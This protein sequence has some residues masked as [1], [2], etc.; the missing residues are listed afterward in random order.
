MR[1]LPSFGWRD[2]LE[3]RLQSQWTAGQTDC[4]LTLVYVLIRFV[5]LGSVCFESFSGTCD[6]LKLRIASVD[7][8]NIEF[9]K[10]PIGGPEEWR[11]QEARERETKGLGRKNGGNQG[12]E[13]VKRPLHRTAA[14]I[15]KRI[16]SN[17]KPKRKTIGLP[18]CP[19][20]DPRPPYC[21]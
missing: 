19:R 20:K 8:C 17:P 12:T 2:L 14:D 18:R 1:Q 7:F 6:V 10:F 5:M 11:A 16:T 21:S 3:R 4:P 9:C 15:A 13:P